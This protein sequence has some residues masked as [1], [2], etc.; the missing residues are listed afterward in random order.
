MRSRCSVAP[1]HDYAWTGRTGPCSP[2]SSG[3]CPG[4]VAGHRWAGEAQGPLARGAA[5]KPAGVLELRD[6]HVAI[7]AVDAFDLE[8]HMIS[9]DIGD[10]AR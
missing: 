2:P 10:T 4:G 8:H 7:H 3:G 6:V 1:T 9:E 5:A